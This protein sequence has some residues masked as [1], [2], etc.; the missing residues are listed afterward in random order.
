MRILRGG[1]ARHNSIASPRGIFHNP[2]TLAPISSAIRL[3]LLSINRFHLVCLGALVLE[4]VVAGAGCHGRPNLRDR[5]ESADPAERIEAI[6]LAADEQNRRLTPAIVDRLDDEDPAVR[7]YA[8]LALE[9][10]TGERLGYQYA[11][12]RSARRAAIDR[13]RVYLKATADER[14]AGARSPGT[15]AEDPSTLD[16]RAGQCP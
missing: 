10:M 14:A 15:R 9:Q 13:W 5:L 6:R 4:V 16:D 12:P 1:C 7:L 3:K 8:I 2:P 11:A